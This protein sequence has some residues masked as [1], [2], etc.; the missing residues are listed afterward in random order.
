MA[1]D[2]DALSAAQIAAGV[3]AGDFSAREV[4]Q[5]ALANVESREGDVHAFLEVSSKLALQT[6]DAID[7]KRAA[8]DDNERTH[9]KATFRRGG[10][11]FNYTGGG[12]A[13][14]GM[15]H[16]GRWRGLCKSCAYRGYYGSGSRLCRKYHCAELRAA[17]HRC[18]HR[19]NE[20]RRSRV[21]A[22]GKHPRGGFT[23]QRAHR[24]RIVNAFS[25]GRVAADRRRKQDSGGAFRQP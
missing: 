21:H 22:K 9:S 11:G 5:A 18:A 8:G 12:A 23:W 1:F 2:I 25:C 17:K 14:A 24:Y 13:L 7:A 16:R 3:A 4:A 6:A 10:D 20:E 19:C 15:L